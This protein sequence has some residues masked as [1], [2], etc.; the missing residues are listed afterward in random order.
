MSKVVI[1]GD[2]V[3]GT[4]LESITGW[5]VES[6]KKTSLDIDNIEKLSNIIYKNDIIVNC[7]AFTDS[8]GGTKDEHWKINY[9]FPSTLSNL[10]L[11]ED[12]KLVH[13][14]TE[15][16]YANNEEPPT[17]EDIPLP[18]NSWYAYSKL[19]ADEYI[20]FT[21]ANALI[22]RLLHK[23]NPFPYPDVWNVKTSGDLVD[24]IAILVKELITKK[25][26]GIFNVGTGDKS[27]SDL[28]PYSKI[29]EPPDHVPKDTRMNIHKLE[30]F[31][32]V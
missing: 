20:S 23:P 26:T 3:L 1:L 8:Y 4:E 5:P 16:V 14:S 7:I 29:V 2:G 21:N 32:N 10:C 19:L 25:A 17:E 31:L 13:I 12:K 18:D 11:I 15:F 6:R 22:C 28:V 9:V 27:L 30:G 24:K